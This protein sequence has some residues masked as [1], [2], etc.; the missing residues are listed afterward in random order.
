LN[1]AAFRIPARGTWGNLPRNAL[2]GPGLWQTDF[3]LAKST[4]LRDNVRLEF[5]AEFFNLFNRAQYANPNANISNQGQFGLITS[6]VNAN[7]TGFGG[8]RQTQFMLRLN[9]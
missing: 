3:T 4:A 7:P 9:F 6:V 5:R 1:F 2:R 8:P